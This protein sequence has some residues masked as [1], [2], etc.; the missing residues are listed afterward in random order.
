M[1][2]F[3]RDH[4]GRDLRPQERQAVGHKGHNDSFVALVAV[5]PYFG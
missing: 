1:A 4:T 5:F 3:Q 2:W